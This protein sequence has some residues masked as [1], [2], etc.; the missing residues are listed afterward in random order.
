M[1]IIA[2]VLQVKQEP[3]EVICIKEEPEDDQALTVTLLD[4]QIRQP[5]HSESQVH[6]VSKSKSGASSLFVVHRLRS[7]NGY[8]ELEWP[9]IE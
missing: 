6:L 7:M 2:F 8:S 1:R 5:C 9:A 3:D 4:C